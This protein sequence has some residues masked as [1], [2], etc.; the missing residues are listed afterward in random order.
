MKHIRNKKIG[1]FTLIELLVVIAIIAILASMLL[2]VLGRAKED[3][4]RM[5]CVNNAKQ[6]G[7]AMQMYSD[8]NSS[9]LPAAHDTVPWGSI[10]PPPWM[11]PLAAYY[12]NTN[13]LTCPSFSQL[14]TK[15]PYNFFMGARAAYIETATNASVSFKKILLTSQYVLSGDCNYAFDPTDAD[16][17]NYSQD[18]LFSFANLPTKG[19]NGWMNILFADEHVRNYN[20]FNTNEITFSYSQP[21]IPWANVTPD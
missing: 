13:I 12:N 19:H 8:D 17:D 7:L 14:F 21:G 10:N 6:L 18:T 20:K 2:P 15:S 5:R 4:V 16:P 1:A 3:A 11:Q 9:L